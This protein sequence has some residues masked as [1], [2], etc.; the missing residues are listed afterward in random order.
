MASSCKSQVT[1]GEE[2]WQDGVTDGDPQ[3]EALEALER[4]VNR[5]GYSPLAFEAFVKWRA[6]KQSHWHGV[7]NFSDIPNEVYNETRRRLVQQID[8]HLAAEPDDV[9]ARAQKDLLIGWPNIKRG[10]TMGNT[11]LQ[12]WGLLFA[13]SVL[14]SVFAES[15]DGEPQ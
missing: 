11:G 1:F 7:S 3:E 9:W 12:E 5:E 6:L 4:V 2:R 10:G 14:E 15:S 13:R 8:A